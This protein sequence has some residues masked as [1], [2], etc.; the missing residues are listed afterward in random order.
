MN[1]VSTSI[2]FKKKKFF[3]LQCRCKTFRFVN[4]TIKSSNLYYVHEKYRSTTLIQYK[5]E[6]A[7]V[8][9]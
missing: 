4:K 1:F 3:Y 9:F 2:E 7:V 5:N 8:N 6:I